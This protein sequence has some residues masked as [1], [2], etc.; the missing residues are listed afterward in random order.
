MVYK[1]CTL[2]NV[3]SILKPSTWKGQ[4]LDWK[5]N[6][7]DEKKI[8]DR[9]PNCKAVKKNILLHIARREDC[10]SAIGQEL[11]KKW[12]KLAYKIKKSMYQ[13][14]YTKSG[15]HK[16]HQAHYMEKLN[17]ED[18]ESV[19]K[20]QRRKSAKYYNKLFFKKNRRF[21]SFNLLC[22][23]VLWYLKKGKCPPEKVL[24]KFHLVEAEL[25][26]KWV[27]RGT[28]KL[29]D[30]DS[31]HK[32]IKKVKYELLASVITFQNFALVPKSYWLSAL[33]KMKNEGKNDLKEKLYRLIGKLQAY[34]H[35]N[36]GDV[37]IPEQFKSTCKATEDHPYAWTPIPDTF[38]DED[39]TLLLNLL[40]D[41][42]GNEVLDDELNKILRVTNDYEVLLKAL[43]YTKRP[44]WDV[45][46]DALAKVK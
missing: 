7:L 39:E 6:H 36:T 31:V 5:M 43:K 23:N 13:R 12:R 24:N 35:E 10:N 17:K 27:E 2:F 34:S 11:L 14:K 45:L 41:I 26:K 29:F 19:L 16:K 1:G 30:S 4:I 32:W 44:R 20:V 22:R 28:D 25:S 46:N 42:I 8:P 9:C 37:E 40:N 18:K 3:H 21:T 38:T 15:K 33:E